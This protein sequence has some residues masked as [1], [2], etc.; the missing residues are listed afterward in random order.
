[1]RIGAFHHLVVSQPAIRTFRFADEMLAHSLAVLERERERLRDVVSGQLELTGGSSLPG[2]L[3]GGDI[4]LHLRVEASA[5]AETVERLREIYD[6]VH[7]EIWSETLATFAGRDPDEDIGIAVTP[8]D[9]EHDRR[10][11]AAWARLRSD[12]EVLASYNAMKRQH[13]GAEPAV[14]LAAKSAFFDRLAED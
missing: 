6:V 14:Y 7:P 3:T 12:P 9:S 11:R 5:F 8:I 1:V 4:D 10:F 13:G 2:A